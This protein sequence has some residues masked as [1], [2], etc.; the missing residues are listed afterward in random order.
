MV[1]D[2]L[3]ALASC[4]EAAQMMTAATKRINRTIRYLLLN[5]IL[6]LDYIFALKVFKKIE[7]RVKF[8]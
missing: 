8:S 1:F 4:A 5:L 2:V 3:A 7:K 6:S